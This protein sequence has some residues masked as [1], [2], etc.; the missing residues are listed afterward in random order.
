MECGDPN[1][2]IY[3]D[4]DWTLHIPKVLLDLAV[5]IPIKCLVVKE[6]NQRESSMSFIIMFAYSFG[7]DRGYNYIRIQRSSRSL[8]TDTHLHACIPYPRA[9]CVCI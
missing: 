1:F 6:R 4:K 7:Q 5:D 9:W 2:E 8:S 3:V